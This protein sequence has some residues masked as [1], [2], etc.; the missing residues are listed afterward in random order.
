MPK[1]TVFDCQGR[2][3]EPDEEPELLARA[4]TGTTTAAERNPTSNATALHQR[5]WQHLVEGFTR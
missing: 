3:I 4:G 2:R 1:T 5:A